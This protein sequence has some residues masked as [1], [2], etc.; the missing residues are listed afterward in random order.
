[1]NRRQ[2]FEAIGGLPGAVGASS[3]LPAEAT[4]APSIATRVWLDVDRWHEHKRQTGESLH[5]YYEGID[6]TQWCRYAEAGEVDGR[7][8]VLCH[9]ATHHQP[10]V[11][12]GCVHLN[13]K[14]GIACS[15]ILRG[16]VVIRPGA[17]L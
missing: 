4:A 2:V 1:V 16:R 13:R 7:A 15:H 9:D 12:G 6:V 11:A 10:L 14:A 5:V 8:E 17:E 3:A